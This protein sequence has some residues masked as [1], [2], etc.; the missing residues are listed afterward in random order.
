MGL[1][2]TGGWRQHGHRGG[3]KV[4]AAAKGA[5]VAGCAGGGEADGEPLGGTDRAPGAHSPLPQVGWPA[6]GGR[7][8][9][10]PLAVACGKGPPV[11]SCPALAPVLAEEKEVSSG[12]RVERLGIVLC[13]SSRGCVSS[14]RE[15]GAG[16]G[17]E[18]RPPDLPLS[19]GCVC[20][21]QPRR[22]TPLGLPV[23]FTSWETEA[24][25]SHQNPPPGLCSPQGPA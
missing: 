4:T 3:T 21:V 11:T 24:G 5:L 13:P 2:L 25:R 7:K 8:L 18:V 1:P 9:P 15:E 14:H 23:P 10:T 16:T 19:L 22:W 6:G 20:F 17:G 12:C